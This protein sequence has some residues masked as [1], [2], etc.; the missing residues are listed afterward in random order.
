M[1]ATFFA[2]FTF[3]GLTK[4]ASDDEHKL[5]KSSLHSIIH[6]PI[7][8]SFFLCFLF[9]FFQICCLLFLSNLNPC[10]PVEREI[11]FHTHSK[12]KKN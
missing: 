8:L 6:L 5:Q 4:L 1:H 10:F 11:L 2:Y 9:F 3:L 12:D 7:L